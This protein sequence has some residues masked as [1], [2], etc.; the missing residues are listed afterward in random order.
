MMASNNTIRKCM[1]RDEQWD[2]FDLK[3]THIK[4]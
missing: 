4:L 2:P 3:F 1:L